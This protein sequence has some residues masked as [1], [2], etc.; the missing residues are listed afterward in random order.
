MFLQLW[1]LLGHTG[2]FIIGWEAYVLRKCV[3]KNNT[4]FFWVKVV[5]LLVL[6]LTCVWLMGFVESV[7]FLVSFARRVCVK[8]AD[9]FFCIG[10]LLFF[11]RRRAWVTACFMRILHQI[12]SIMSVVVWKVLVVLLLSQGSRNSLPNLMSK[13]ITQSA[14]SR[15]LGTTV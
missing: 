10:S 5:V 14:K 9:G 8:L 1:I 11:W 6:F 13:L 7:V 4:G 3:L 2:G 15:S 12:K